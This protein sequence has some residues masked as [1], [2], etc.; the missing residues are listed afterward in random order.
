MT[1]CFRRLLLV[2]V[3]GALIVLLPSCAGTQEAADG[4]RDNGSNE[5]QPGLNLAPESETVKTI[6]LYRGKNE[7][8]LPIIELPSADALTLAFDILDEDAGPL[9]VYFYHADRSW[10]RDF[11]STRFLSGFQSDALIDYTPSQGTEVG[12]THY[13]YRFP[14]NDI[15]FKASGNY[16]LRVTRQGREDEVLFERPF[17]VTEDAGSLDLGIE[18]LIVT[19]QRQPSDRPIARFAPSST[20]GTNRYDYGVCFVRNG[21]FTTTRCA[22][23]SRI[24]PQDGYA[25]ELSRDRAFAP[26]PPARALDLS[27]LRISAQVERV[28]RSTSPFELL[29]Q[30]DYARFSGTPFPDPLFGQTIVSD[31]TTALARPNVAAEYVRTT[32]AFVPPGESPVDGGVVVGGSFSGGR[33][34]PRYRMTWVDSAKRYEGDVLLKQGRYEYFYATTNPELKATL[35]QNVPPTTDRYL[36]LVYYRDVSLN[37]DRLVKVGSVQGV[38]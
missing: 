26:T 6:Q 17:F 20:L 18:G 21:D 29:L 23:R 38:R 5:R 12:Y 4:P 30:P 34:N 16:I 1:L 27:Q 13:R 24:S 37:S 31:A 3:S 35:A 11:S 19:G 32:F 22:D 2:L 25:F 7:A 10:E 28:D 33:V 9:T 15:Q 36:A 14:N 8:A